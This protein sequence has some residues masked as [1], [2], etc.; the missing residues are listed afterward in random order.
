MRSVLLA[1]LILCGLASPAQAGVF[2]DDLSRCLV[3][4]LTDTDRNALMAWMFSAI[5]ADPKLQ[6][7]TTLDRA[8]RD[9]IADAAAGV[10]QRLM[11][12]DCRKEAVA[13]LKSEGEDT[14]MTSFEE[15]GRAATQQLFRSPEAQA[16][17]ESLGKG[18]DKEKL[19]ALL[20]EAGIS[21]KDDHK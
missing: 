7:Y 10:S 4:H 12:S 19:K 8:G 15:V 17:L 14:L 6:K 2:G 16:E 21:T 13:A 3:N 5:S 18:F 11:V 9:R 20:S 1:G